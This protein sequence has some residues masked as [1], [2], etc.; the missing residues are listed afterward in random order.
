MKTTEPEI[1]V[2]LDI[3]TTKIVAIVGKKNEHG[4]IEILGLGK[5]ESK[6]VKRGVVSN[7]AQTAD[8]IRIAVKKAEDQSGVDIRVV[9]VGIAGHHIRSIQ[10]TWYIARDNSEEEITQEDIDTLIDGMYKLQMLPGEE[11]IH[12]LPQEYTVDGEKGSDNPIG[13]SGSRLGADFHVI[14]GQVAAAKNIFKCAEKAG[15]KVSD[16]VLEPLASSESVLQDQ[17]K[18][19]GVA[20]VDIGGGTT[21][22][23]VFQD[24]IIRHTA[25]IPM[26]GNI[27]TEDIMDGCSIIKDK[28]ECLKIQFGSALASEMQENE[29]VAIPDLS[30][31]YPKE[32][33]VKN[34]ANI[35]QSRMKDIV[36]LIYYEIK[37]SGYENKLFAGIVLTGGGS[38]L[39]HISQMFEY[40]TGITT[41]VGYPN[42]HLANNV[43][44]EIT[45][46]IY[47][48]GIGLV[49]KGF[50]S[51]DKQA[52]K[53]KKIRGHSKKTKG[54]FFDIFFKK[55]QEFFDEKDITEEQ[56]NH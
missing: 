23:A 4:K 28:A 36:E 48:T 9:N 18:E 17:D 31:K 5:T 8:S 14:L 49:M 41:R 34:L 15:L 11:I 26:G 2:S 43:I 27:I 44:K 35:I 29:V 24:R 20:L 30:G 42:K 13:M 1:V 22:I 46:P 19:A 7:I 51:Q 54:K 12:V 50:A 37:N 3:G 25:V 33:S 32:I 56:S 40:Y 52:N 38:Q 47:A 55:T 45:S 16:L 6:G 53:E 39:K 21:D 10:Q